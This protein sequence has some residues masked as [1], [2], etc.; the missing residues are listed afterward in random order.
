MTFTMRSGPGPRASDPRRREAGLELHDR[1][2]N[3]LHWSLAVPRNAVEV[4]VD[5]DIVTLSGVVEKT[6]ERSC[7]EALAQRVPGVGQVRNE[8]A[9][10]PVK[11]S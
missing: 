7:A 9:V 5:G 2:A 6:Y 3:A 4:R 11:P 1:V 8:I 10:R